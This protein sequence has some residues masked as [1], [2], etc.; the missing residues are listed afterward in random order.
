M[1]MWHFGH[2]CLYGFRF[3]ETELYLTNFDTTWH[4]ER[5]A[6]STFFAADVP[7]AVR[8]P[9]MSPT[10]VVPGFDKADNAALNAGYQHF[11]CD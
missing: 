9:F 6:A 11:T 7:R 8:A 1:R 10:M 2:T 4:R 3:L 5:G